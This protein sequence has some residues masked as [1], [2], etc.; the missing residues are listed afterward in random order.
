[1]R[2]PKAPYAH[3][4]KYEGL[5]LLRIL[6]AVF[7]VILHSTL[8]TKER[9][10]PSEQLWSPGMSGV[11]IFFVLSGF[12]MIYSSQPLWG[13]P[14]GWRVFAE[15]RVARIVPMYWLATTIK[16]ILMIS[17]SREILHADLSPHTALASYL[18]LPYTNRDGELQP[19]LGVG[20]TLNFEMFFY[21]LFSLALFLKVNVYRFLGI[22]LTLLALGSYFRRPGWP[23][24]A[25]YLNSVVLDFL[26]G[27][28]IAKFC[29]AKQFLPFW[30]AVGSTA[31][32]LAFLVFGIPY[33]PSLPEAL[34]FGVPATM[35]VWGVASLEN[36]LPKIPS[37]ILLLADASYLIYLYH[38]FAGPL[39]P[40][41]LAKLHLL[42][43]HLAVLISLVLSLLL[44]TTAY[45][46]LDRPTTNYLRDKLRIRH[47]RIIA[48]A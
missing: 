3:V 19:L 43:P 10:L 14:L 22:I 28:L 42:M 7:V 34:S 44:G 39:A 21:A 20:W 13:H 27:M 15:R 38:S 36:R 12:V 45:M 11:D 37:F 8:Y 1:M 35:M 2:S 30:C 33:L 25:F 26:F 23:P 47:R 40:K 6:A 5:Q 41:V 46:L 32:G 16:L 48:G 4:S 9:L 24:A 29:L 17:G 31:A 18:F